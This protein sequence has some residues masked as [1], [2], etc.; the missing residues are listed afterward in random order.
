MYGIVRFEIKDGVVTDSRVYHKFYSK[1]LSTAANNIRKMSCDKDGLVSSDFVHGEGYNLFALKIFAREFCDGM[2]ECIYYA[3]KG[4]DNHTSVLW[5]LYE[6]TDPK[7]I[8]DEPVTD[9]R[10]YKTIIDRYEWEKN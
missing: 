7:Y 10:W 5:C 6:T 2:S 1:K 4:I 8:Y 3:I 9:L